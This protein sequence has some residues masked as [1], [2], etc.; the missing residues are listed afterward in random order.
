MIHSPEIR[1]EGL[2]DGYRRAS[3]NR[4][5]HIVGLSAKWKLSH[6]PDTFHS[7]QAANTTFELFEKVR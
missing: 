5:G 6:E 1:I 4:E 3:F 7:R 2:I